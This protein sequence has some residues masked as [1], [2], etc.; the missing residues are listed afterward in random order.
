MYNKRTGRVIV[1]LG[2]LGSGIQFVWFGVETAVSEGKKIN[3]K[4]V[5]EFNL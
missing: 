5:V 1:E 3:L 2:D 4:S